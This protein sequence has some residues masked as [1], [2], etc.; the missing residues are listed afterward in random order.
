MR[1]EFK[2]YWFVSFGTALMLT[3][4]IH[5]ALPSDAHADPADEL[6]SKLFERARE[7]I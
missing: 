6:N 3:A 7:A 5:L 4:Y 1:K 2:D